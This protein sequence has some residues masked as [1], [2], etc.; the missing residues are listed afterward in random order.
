M[1]IFA[2]QWFEPSTSV[3]LLYRKK[4]LNKKKIKDRN[5]SIKST[6]QRRT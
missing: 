3:G 4:T 2:K 1:Y 5:P 6:R